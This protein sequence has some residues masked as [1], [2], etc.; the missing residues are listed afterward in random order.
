MEDSV[1]W[2][3]GYKDELRASPS[4]KVFNI[5]KELQ[6]EQNFAIFCSCKLMSGG[7]QMVVGENRG[8]PNM[9]R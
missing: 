8:G 9:L 6:T 7:K 4:I 1:R 3:Q 5:W 2:Y